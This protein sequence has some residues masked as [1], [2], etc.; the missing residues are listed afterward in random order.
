ME[1]ITIKTD[2]ARAV[3]RVIASV[4]RSVAGADRV[5]PSTLVNDLHIPMYRKPNITRDHHVDGVVIIKHESGLP[6]TIVLDE[7][8]SEAD[9]TIALAIALGIYALQ[10]PLDASGS[11]DTI[12][13]KLAGNDASAPV[14]KWIRRFAYNLSMPEDAV[15]AQ[16]TAGKT[17]KQI[18]K[19]FKVTAKTMEAR[20][21]DLDLIPSKNKFKRIGSVVRRSD[22]D[23]TNKRD[24]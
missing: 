1:G 3:E 21:K 24:L 16:W 20:L 9:R 7:T 22:I 4:G 5:P 12:A 2:P 13:I 8:V 17:V 6:S 23:L 18:S 14:K 11:T 19:R 10:D 15:A